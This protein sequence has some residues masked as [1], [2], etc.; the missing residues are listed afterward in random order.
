MIL[1]IASMGTERI[2]PG[3]PHIQ[4]QKTSEMTD[5][6]GIEGEPSGQKHRRY[7]LALDQ[8]KSKVKRS[9]SS[10]PWK[11]FGPDPS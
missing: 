9:R 5:E 7:S 3:I 11:V 2:A 4:N 8:M 10:D 6:D 1:V